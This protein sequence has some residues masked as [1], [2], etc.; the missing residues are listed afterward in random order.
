MRTTIDAAGQISV[1]KSILAE[2]G[3][4]AETQLELRVLDNHLEVRLA[5]RVGVEDGRTASASSRMRAL[6]STPRT[7]VS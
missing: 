1:P 3:F 6:A 5:S 2:L 4:D 7:Y